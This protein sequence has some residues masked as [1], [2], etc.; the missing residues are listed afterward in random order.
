R[1]YGRYAQVVGVSQNDAEAAKTF[2]REQGDATFDV[3]FDPEPK[4]A[5]SNAYDVESVPHHVLVEKDG[6]VSTIF[7][8]WNR[9]EID[10][11]PRR[12]VEDK[13]V[14][15]VPIVA[16]DDPVPAMKPG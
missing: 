2:Y 11:L 8:G 7:S 3:V 1:Q 15:L 9:K 10:S 6:T 4:F 14:T 5:A 13:D 12:L 16:A